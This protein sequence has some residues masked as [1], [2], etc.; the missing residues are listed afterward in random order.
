MM[1][2]TS[3]SSAEFERI[4][5]GILADRE[6]IVRHNPIGTREES[7]LWMLMSSLVVYL[8]LNELETPCF[9]GRPDAKTYREAIEFILRGRKSDEFDVIPL[10]DKLSLD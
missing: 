1:T 7:L 3:I 4:V 10:L 5:D 2:M 8:S 6:S 9:T